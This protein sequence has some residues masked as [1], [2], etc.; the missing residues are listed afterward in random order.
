MAEKDNNTADIVAQ[1]MKGLAPAI[2]EAVK[3]ARMTPDELNELKKP[4][5]DPIKEASD[6]R[7]RKMTQAEIKRGLEERKFRQDNCPHKITSP[8]GLNTTAISIV[9]DMINSEPPL[10]PYGL[11]VRCEKTIKPQHWVVDYDKDDPA[12][13]YRL[14]A[15]DPLYNK[16]LELVESQVSGQNY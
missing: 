4:Y 11:C 6:M 12:G 14:V 13:K 10:Q 2:G 16:V 3:N 5:R 7:L 15:P 1:V 9:H 8:G